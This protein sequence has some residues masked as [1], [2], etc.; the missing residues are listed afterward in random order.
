[1]PKGSASMHLIEKGGVGGGG[2]EEGEEEEEEEEEGEG[3][4]GEE[5]GGAG[6]K[7]GR[8]KRESTSSSSSSSAAAA[9]RA[10]AAAAAAASG[11]VDRYKGVSIRVSFSDAKES[12]AI[13]LLSGGQRTLVALALIFAIQR[14]DPA[15]F[16]VFDEIDSALDP[17]H[18]AAVGALIR[19][20]AQQKG[21]V[22]GGEAAGG[23]GSSGGKAAPIQ[24]ILSTFHP[25]ILQ[26]G[27]EFFGV[28]LQG[29]T[30]RVEKMTKPAAVTFV[31]AILDEE[32][33]KENS[34]MEAGGGGAGGKKKA[35]AAVTAGGEPF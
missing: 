34:G 28:V 7:K 33:S 6:G 32:R 30:S 4:E 12:S 29:K 27:E 14:N 17:I 31:K 1:V 23:G 15:P 22:G 25:E 5:G 16:Y 2:E 13:G 19:K 11:A 9:K 8:K 3:G 24:F 20:Q 10:A 35:R 26:Y 18:R 21:G